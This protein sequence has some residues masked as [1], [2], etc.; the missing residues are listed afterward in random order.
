MQPKLQQHTK[1]SHAHTNLAIHG[2]VYR[3]MQGLHTEIE[4]EEWSKVYDD[5]ELF[6]AD[7]HKLRTNYRRRQTAKQALI[8]ASL[9]FGLFVFSDILW[10]LIS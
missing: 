10:K 7:L 9:L 8:T 5:T 2:A 6:I 3:K 4:P 1:Q